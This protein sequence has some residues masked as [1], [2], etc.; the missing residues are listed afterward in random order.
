[1]I[2]QPVVAD[3][4][5]AKITHQV[6]TTLNLQ[7]KVADALPSDAKGLVPPVANLV[8]GYVQG[9]ISEV[10]QSPRFYALWTGTLRFTH[11]QVIAALEG[12]GNALRIKNGEVVLNLLPMVNQALQQLEPVVSG[13]VGHQVHFPTITSSTIPES[14]RNKLSDALG[15]PIPSDFG[16]V[17]LIRSNAL[18]TVTNGVSLFNLLAWLLPLVTAILLGAVI[19]LSL[20][21]RRSLLQVAIG[22]IV[23]LVVVRR[24]IFWLETHLIHQA[25]NQAAASSIFHQLLGGLLSVTVWMLVVACLAAVA[26]LI[27]GPYAWARWLRTNVARL[28]R[29]TGEGIVEIGDALAG[30]ATGNEDATK[31]VINHRTILQAAGAVLGAILLLVLP[32]VWFLVVAGLLVIYEVVLARISLPPPPGPELNPSDIE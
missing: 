24:V 7:A 26:L 18:E 10:L 12:G 5:A 23:L 28:G 27:A 22:T 17:V 31:W 15:V 29:R 6:Q 3:A 16:N 25:A 9:K 1:V 30:K 2:K 19:W 14:A 11:E 4:L 13:L 20:N 8:R 32:F 21:K